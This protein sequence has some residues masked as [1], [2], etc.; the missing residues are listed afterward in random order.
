M[1]L[2]DRDQFW[3]FLSADIQDGLNLWL[4]GQ[5]SHITPIEWLGGGKSGSPIAVISRPGSG[6]DDQVLLKFCHVKEIN[7]WQQAI[8]DSDDSYRKKHLVEMLTNSL[9]TSG[10]NPWW[11]AM[12]KIAAGD[13]SKY[14]PMSEL[15]EKTGDNFAHTC[16]VIT[17]SLIADW[18]PKPRR[19]S[20]SEVPR[21]DFL[22][23]VFQINRV[24]RGKP[25]RKWFD[26]TFQNFDDPILQRRGWPD[27]QPNPF[28]FAREAD[29]IA[30]RNQIGAQYGRAH[31]DLH[32]GNILM[33]ADPPDAS[34]YKLIDLGE[35][36]PKAPLARDPMYL[37]LSI[38]LDW[39]GSGI[40]PGS[41][42]SQK[43]I[44]IIVKPR[45]CNE[46]K[47]YQVVSQAIHEA[48]REIAADNG[49]G[50]Q[51][52]EQSLLLLVGCALRYASKTIA[53]FSDSN[54]LRGWF[55]E[56]AVLAARAYLEE[57][58]LWEDYRDSHVMSSL[59]RQPSNPLRA[60]TNIS[61]RLSVNDPDRKESGAEAEAE[62]EAEVIPLPIPPQ[63]SPAEPSDRTTENFGIQFTWEQLAEVLRETNFEGSS[64][65]ELARNTGPL[66]EAITQNY[67]IHP[68]HQDE[69]Q[70]HLNR[71][72]EILNSTLR[73]GT[74][75]PK[76]HSTCMLAN[77]LR[78][79]LLALI[80][81][82][83]A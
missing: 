28:I 35:Y 43:L 17:S 49:W 12:L 21:K 71:L 26:A 54:A 59:I 51:W 50:K 6:Y 81:E 63:S 56:V 70:S 55:F 77:N 10:N 69:I 53:N 67:P 80:P 40:N 30:G 45:E 41:P 15:P 64:W 13:T 4:S 37:L 74:S 47:E 73:P 29:L 61:D 46:Q 5:P 1:T 14:R 3:S 8:Q 57:T 52:R 62:A 25:L 68:F 34:D 72:H 65:E 27:P 60:V 9:I 11:I 7:K 58:G 22:E 78:G 19:H 82:S 2:Q 76:L 32:L 75:P 44:P 33:P 20:P 36:D 39:I 48:G 18:N 42:L 16:K 66:L 31:G 79:Y 24:V 83:K 38:A 23:E